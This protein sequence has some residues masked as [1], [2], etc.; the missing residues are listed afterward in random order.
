MSG[1]ALNRPAGAVL[2]ADELVSVSLGESQRRGVP[3]QRGL[4][5]TQ[6]HGAGQHRFRQR[7]GIV[8]ASGSARA[9]QAGF[10]ITSPMIQFLDVRE[11]EVFELLVRVD[12]KS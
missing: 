6:G 3:M 9:A 4:R 2:A 11:L 5:E 1:E 12:R 8:E 7:P 10:H